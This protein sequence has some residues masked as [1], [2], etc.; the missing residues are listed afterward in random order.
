VSLRGVRH[1]HEYEP[2][3]G[4][5]ERLPADERVLWQGT[6]AMGPLMRHAFHMRALAV[7]FVLMVLLRAVAIWPETESLVELMLRLLWP[8]GLA[9][10]G[11]AMV[12]VLARMTCRSAVYT[13]TN[14][15]VV[16]RVGVVLSVTFNLPLRSIAS[17][18]LRPL[19]DG[20]GDI[21][22]R[23]S[24][25]E[26]IGYVHLWPHA[27]PWRVGSPEPMLRCLPEAQSVAR[28]LTQAWAQ[29]N[30]Q[31]AQAGSAAQAASPVVGSG[32]GSARGDS[33]APLATA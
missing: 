11:W 28:V 7:Y 22:L 32:L 18:D 31:S 23:L 8:I 26:R 19:A 6:P 27:R 2:Q 9:A 16:L 4:L 30:Q 33:S 25:P 14:K 12:A 15:R 13:I 21:A 1:E 29:A 24:G 3:Y 20:Y 5:P 17:A 10:L